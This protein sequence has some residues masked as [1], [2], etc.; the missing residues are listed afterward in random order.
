MLKWIKARLSDIGWWFY[1]LRQ[2]GTDAYKEGKQARIDG[3]CFST[4]PYPGITHET[5]SWDRGWLDQSIKER[6][7]AKAPK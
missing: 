2:K 5:L 3:G 1:C 6:K 7:N 4:N